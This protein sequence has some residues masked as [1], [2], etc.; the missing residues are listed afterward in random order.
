MSNFVACYSVLNE[1][2]FLG[3]SLESVLPWVDKVIIVEGAY[4]NHVPSNRGKT[5]SIDNT[6]EVIKGFLDNPKVTYVHASMQNQNRQRDQYLK[7]LETGDIMLMVDG[8]EL[9]CERDLSFI[10]NKFNNDQGLT[11]MKIK[12]VAFSK[13]FRHH[14]AGYPYYKSGRISAY[15]YDADW[16]YYARKNGYDAIH[17][18]ENN[19][20]G[21]GVTHHKKGYSAK[22]G[23]CC[24]LHAK[25]LKP[26]DLLAIKDSY[27]YVNDPHAMKAMNLKRKYTAQEAVRMLAARDQRS[28]PALIYN[29]RLPKCLIDH[30]L[31]PPNGNYE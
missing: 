19:G 23:E 12:H 13:D 5:T 17:L 18:W 25:F 20:R 31:A 3:Y 2:D 15:R 11:W 22:L 30:P 16:K 8:D 21:N 26:N 6:V 7:Y 29:G 9:Y 14:W 27:Y 28:K 4:K 10:R 1:G 24:T